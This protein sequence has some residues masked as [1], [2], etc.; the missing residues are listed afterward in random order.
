[1][2]A[3]NGKVV[4]GYDDS[5]ASAIALEWAAR[6]AQRRGVP[7]LVVHAVG[8]AHAGLGIRDSRL[9]KLQQER[10]QPLVA[11]AVERARSLTQ[12]PVDGKTVAASVVAA[13]QEASREAALIV[14]GHRHMGALRRALVGSA[15]F[16]VM[17]HAECPVQI[18]RG[19][20]HALPS[21]QHPV[22]VG[23]DGSAHSYVALDHAADLAADTGAPL[24]IVVAWST[25]APEMSDTAYTRA[26]DGEDEGI[27]GRDPWQRSSKPSLLDEIAGE[28]TQTANSTAEAAIRH[29]RERHA[30]LDVVG[31]VR[32]GRPEDVI[33]DAAA[34][35]AGLIVVGARGHG[36]LASL[37]LGS[38]SR[39]VVQRAPCTVAVVR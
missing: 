4:V 24:H 11:A 14:L 2:T 27:A 38:V 17:T 30:Q 36:D 35:G 3:W 26:V 5:Q 32:Q 15:A 6:V 13:L 16:A 31:M 34:D 21:A 22:V 18:V 1:M 29:T 33:I 19:P 20:L 39:R 12:V 37:L 28:I 7:L 8:S 10:A 9:T 25:L 23:V